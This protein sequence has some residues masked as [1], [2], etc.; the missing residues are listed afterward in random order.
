MHPYPMD[1]LILFVTGRCN[2]RCQHCFYWQNLGRDHEGLEINQLAQIASSMP[3]FRTLLLSGG[4]P[5]L[6][7]DLPQ[8][9]R[10]FVTFNRIRNI[11]IPTNGLLPQELTLLAEEIASISPKLLV[12]FNVSID[13][14]ADIHD[15]VRGVPGAY[16]LAM[17]SLSRLREVA[18]KHTN[19]RVW[20][21]TVIMTV[22]RS[23][24]LDL[25][26]HILAS[27]LADGHFFEIIRGGPPNASLKAISPE[28]LKA[29][30]KRLLPIQATYL[31]R[32][33]KRQRGSIFGILRYI[34]DM[35]NLI[36]RYYHQWKVY[37]GKGTWS[38][39]CLAGQNIGVID[40][41]GKLRICELREQGVDLKDFGFNFRE[42]WNSEVVRHESKIARSHLCD[43]THT[44]FIGVSM[45]RNFYARFFQSAFL[46]VRFEM[47]LLW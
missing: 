16:D 4:E 47:G 3:S 40:Y 23:Q 6:R 28:T 30:Y 42:A 35:S 45:R 20:V 15:W 41:S 27:E 10:I 5:T 34:L 2:A 18:N 31:L 12:S 38:F 22:N 21:N 37:A 25:A 39:P 29:L 36:N 32:E 19:L 1:M 24:I 8:L 9:I 33:A 26:N 43:C 44:C 13:G 46:F 7:K 14:F 17:E 11:S